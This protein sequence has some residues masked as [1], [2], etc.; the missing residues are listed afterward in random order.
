[1]ELKLP[2]VLVTCK[3]KTKDTSFR[4]EN[5]GLGLGFDFPF[6]TRPS[7]LKKKG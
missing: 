4:D 6:E 1:M 5:K 3:L 2:R 7:E